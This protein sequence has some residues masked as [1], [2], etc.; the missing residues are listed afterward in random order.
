MPFLILQMYVC[1]SQ[2]TI[3]RETSL[4]WH[5]MQLFTKI[6]IH[7]ISCY[8]II[9]YMATLRLPSLMQGPSN[10]SFK[11]SHDHYPMHRKASMLSLQFTINYFMNFTI[12][13]YVLPKILFVLLALLFHSIL[14]TSVQNNLLYSLY[15][16]AFL[17][18]H[19]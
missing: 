2:S 19:Q 8:R 7:K 5:F 18:V 6:M 13:L 12:A 3:Y 11:S 15:K 10:C 14:T 1:V 4:K 9:L 16:L 17:W